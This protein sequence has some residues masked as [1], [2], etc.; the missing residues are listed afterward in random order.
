MPLATTGRRGQV[1]VAKLPQTGHGM[2]QATKVLQ[3]LAGYTE[4]TKCHRL[5]RVFR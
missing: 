2:L 3:T 1:D 5:P 4:V